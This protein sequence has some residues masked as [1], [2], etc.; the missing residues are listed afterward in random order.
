MIKTESGINVNGV[1]AQ[2]LHK[3]LIKKFKRK[4]VYSRFKD[5]IWVVDFPGISSLS[6]FNRGV[7]YLLCVINLFTKYAWVKLLPDKKAETVLHGFVGIVNESKCN[8]YLNR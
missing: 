4:K 2:E 6:S 7:K 5:Y 8:R 1:L 3:L